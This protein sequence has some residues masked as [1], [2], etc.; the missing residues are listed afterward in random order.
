M[1]RDGLR[2]QANRKRRTV[3]FDG[4]A[5]VFLGRCIYLQ[6][7]LL[8]SIVLVGAANSSGQDLGALAREEQARKQ[9]QSIHQS[10]A[11]TN[12]DLVRPQ[13]LTTDD[14]MKFRSSRQNWKPMIVEAPPELAT[15]TG[16]PE[17]P[18]GDIARQYSEQKV[19]RQ[20]RSRMEAQ[21]IRSSHVYTNEDM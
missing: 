1:W 7:I 11:Y 3:L 18:L 13:I 19:A 16:P 4:S 20:Q 2:Q 15:E 9:A 17:V 12:D 10:H 21:P 8:L 14:E 6:V 5:N